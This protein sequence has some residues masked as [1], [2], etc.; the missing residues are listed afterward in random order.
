MYPAYSREPPGQVM[1][2]PRA[3]Q[4]TGD[5]WHPKTTAPTGAIAHARALPAAPT[6][7]AALL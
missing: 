7:A 2:S 1:T 6:R 5:G 4:S 3:G